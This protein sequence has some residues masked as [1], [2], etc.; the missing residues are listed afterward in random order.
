VRLR[1]TTTDTILA[2]RVTYARMPWVRAIGY[3]GRREVDVREGLWFERC[4][5]VHTFGMRASIDV[6]FLDCDRTVVRIA[7]RARR[8]RMFHGGPRA[9]AVLELGPGVTDA[10]VRIGDRLALE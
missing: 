10:G 7:P 9:T 1:N 3:L 2:E 6:V 4:A 8:N 5:S